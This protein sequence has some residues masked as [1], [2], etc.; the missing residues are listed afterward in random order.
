MEQG[1]ILMS[2][3]ELLTLYKALGSL[4]GGNVS[5]DPASG[6]IDQ[7]LVKIETI[8]IERGEVDRLMKDD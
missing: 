2:T 6:P 5:D 4:N 3:K 1:L 8:L 7:T